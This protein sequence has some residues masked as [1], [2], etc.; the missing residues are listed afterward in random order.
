MPALLTGARIAFHEA[1]PVRCRPQGHVAP[2][3]GGGLPPEEFLVRIDP[4]LRGLRDRLFKDTYT[5]DV[6]A[7]GLTEEWARKLDSNAGSRWQRRIRRPP[8]APSALHH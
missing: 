2:P 8:W 1:R 3:D 7:G 5:S 6:S 4:L